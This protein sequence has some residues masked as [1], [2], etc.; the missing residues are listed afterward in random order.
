M[1]EKTTLVQQRQPLTFIKE[2]L[3]LQD[4]QDL[5]SRTQLNPRSE[6]SSVARREPQRL[7]FKV[8]SLFIDCLIFVRVTEYWPILSFILINSSGPFTT[9]LNNV[10]TG[11]D[12]GSASGFSLKALEA[13]PEGFFADTH[14][15]EFQAGA[16]RGNLYRAQ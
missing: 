6:S 12:T 11:V 8:S 7:V 3:E 14:T 2:T 15:F 1:S 16:I 4:L 10:D 5:P 9:G 13:N